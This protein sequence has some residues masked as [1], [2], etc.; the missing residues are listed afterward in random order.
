MHRTLKEETTNPPARNLLEQ[1]EKFDLFQHQFN[2]SRPHEALEMKYPSEVHVYSKKQY[3]DLEE[4]E[5]PEHDCTTKVSSCGKISMNSKNL[6]VSSVLAYQ[7]LGIK[8]I[9]E[10][11]WKVTFMN[12]DLG[13]F[14][15]ESKKLKTGNNPFL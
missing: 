14:D 7:N 1:Q 2:N 8:R 10:D 11:V 13:F 4:L 12:Y 15:Y 6:Y 9:D 5:Y 3:H